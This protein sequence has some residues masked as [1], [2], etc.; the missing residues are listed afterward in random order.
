M[1]TPKDSQSYPVILSNFKTYKNIIRRSI[2]HAKRDYYR[3]AFNRYSTNLQ[4]TWVTINETLNRKKVKRNFP[5]EFKLTNGNTISEPKEIA[6][7]FKDCFV[8][9]GDTGVLNTNRNIDVVELNLLYKKPT[10]N[11]STSTINK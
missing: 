8:S 9:I 4:K 11:H 7:A 2:M 1:Q 5:K 10:L 6:N 3:H